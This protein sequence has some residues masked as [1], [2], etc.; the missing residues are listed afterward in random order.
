MGSWFP[1]SGESAL[2]RPHYSA[3]DENRRIQP[4]TACPNRLAD[5]S[6]SE[7]GGVNAVIPA[8]YKTARRILRGGE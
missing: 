3:H 1:S 7:R 4:Y 2:A 6:W 5:G 8:A